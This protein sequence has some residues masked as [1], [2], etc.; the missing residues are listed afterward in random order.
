MP[1]GQPG[2]CGRVPEGVQRHVAELGAL[3]C[4]LV[5]PVHGLAIRRRGACAAGIATPLRDWA[6]EKPAA[7]IDVSVEA[8]LAHQP[9]GCS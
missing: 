3:Q 7:V 1:G 5:P 2:R 6:E 8:V 4:S 9:E